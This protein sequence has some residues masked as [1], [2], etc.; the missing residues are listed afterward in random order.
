[1]AMIATTT[2][3]STN[4]K[5][6]RKDVVFMDGPLKNPSALTGFLPL[7]RLPNPLWQRI[8]AYHPPQ[9]FA[10]FLVLAGRAIGLG[11]AVAKRIFPSD[12]AAGTEVPLEL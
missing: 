4:E 8:S 10:M 5:A 6:L 12:E 9:E 7:P 2:S 11:W 3:S 1:M